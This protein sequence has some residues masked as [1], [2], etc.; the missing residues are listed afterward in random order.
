MR[1]NNGFYHTALGIP[2]PFCNTLVN[3]GRCRG[4]CD[5][6]CRTVVP[7][8][9]VSGTLRQNLDEAMDQGTF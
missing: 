4:Y 3:V 2:T 1:G 6:N 9:P 7:G 5:R 8:L